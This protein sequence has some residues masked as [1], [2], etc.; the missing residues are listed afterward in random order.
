M[1]EQVL[2]PARPSVY[3]IVSGAKTVSLTLTE[4]GIAVLQ[5]SCRP[6]VKYW[7]IKEVLH[8]FNK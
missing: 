7:F 5:K 2:P 1:W 4:I 8:G 3:G 6:R